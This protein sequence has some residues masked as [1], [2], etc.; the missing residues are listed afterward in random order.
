VDKTLKKLELP[1]V[2]AMLADLCTSSLGKELVE[3]MKPSTEL[4]QLVLWQQETTEA[5]EIWR[6]YPNVPLG[7]LRDV[8][9]YLKRAELGAS[10]EPDDFLSID[11]T[12]RLGRRLRRFCLELKETYS[13][14]QEYASQIE[15]FPD[16]ELVIEK[17]FDQEGN[18]KNDASNEL[19]Q[20]RRKI[21]NLNEK[22]KAKL[23]NIIRSQTQQK[24]LQDSIITIR[25]DRYV[26]PVKQE[27]R[28]N[29]PGIVHDQSSS[30]AT[31]FIEPNI[32]VQLNN[33]LRTVSIEEKRE[34][35]RILQTLTDKVRVHMGDLIRTVSYLAKLD[36]IFAKG[37][38]SEMMDGVEP[39]LNKDGQIKLIRA[40]HPLIHGKVVPISL[41]LGYDFHTLVVT[42]PNTG[43]KTVSL[44]TV[45]LLSLMSQVGLHIPA[46]VGSRIAVFDNIFTDIGDEQSIEQSLSTFSAHMKNIID[47]VNKVNNSSLVLLD[48]LGAGTDPTEGAALARALLDY[49]H[50]IGA[51]TIATTHYSELKTFAYSTPGVKNAS[52]E[53]DSISLRPTYKLLIGLPGRSNALEIALQLGLSE[54][55]ITNARNY[56]SQEEIHV[57]DMIQDLEENRKITLKER[58]EVELLKKEIESLKD[59]LQRERLNLKNKESKIIAKAIA[60]AEQIIRESKQ[61]ADSILAELRSKLIL[62]TERAQEIITQQAKEQLRQKE[63]ILGEQSKLYKRDSGTPL[64]EIKI[65]DHVL[66][67]SLGQ[68]GIILT[69][70]NQQGEVLV[71]AGIMKISVK[72]TDL[73]KVKDKVDAASNSGFRKVLISNEK[74]LSN[75]LDLRGLTIDEALDKVEKYL[76]NAVL[77]N[78]GRVFLIHGKGTGALRKAIQDHLQ[79]HIHVKSTRLGEPGEGGTG[80]TVAEL[81]V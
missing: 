40:R 38:L 14:I 48:E 73:R 57:S 68:R 71:Q 25:G 60:K 19:L 28:N 66:I 42:G 74:T 8:R 67:S 45:G 12:I 72:T 39:L 79:Y 49:F 5:R 17:T 44:K 18:I 6:L 47:I 78:L 50:K 51:K 59:N 58:E 30:G 29:F 65:G 64:K 10:L 61:E 2:L 41:E 22:I 32:V 34:I 80:V 16:L 7:G 11:D 46:D 35:A 55:I 70:P 15:I 77:N 20:L 36:L 62:E 24:Y 27:Y 37:R 54:N 4:E 76:D 56:I 63:Q 31:L 81:K 1:R 21:T 3:K 53:F 23:E 33:E 75:E 9:G 43:G 52:V 13:N 26:I 69:L